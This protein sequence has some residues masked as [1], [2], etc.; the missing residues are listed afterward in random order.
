VFLGEVG[1]RLHAEVLLVD[2]GARNH[3]DSV[4]DWAHGVA[5]GATGAIFLH[6][7]RERVVAIELDG[8]VA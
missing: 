1:A 8:L 6:D 2:H 4:L 3:V 5:N 7:L